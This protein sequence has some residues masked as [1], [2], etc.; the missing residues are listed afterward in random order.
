MIDKCWHVWRK[1]DWGRNNKKQCWGCYWA[2]LHKRICVLR[3][4]NRIT[5]RLNRL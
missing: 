4:L 2:G 5:K 1:R 3:A